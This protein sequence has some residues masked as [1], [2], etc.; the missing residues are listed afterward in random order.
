MHQPEGEPSATAP[1]DAASQPFGGDRDAE[2]PFKIGSRES[3]IPFPQGVGGDQATAYI[4]QRLKQLRETH[5]QR[6]KSA[7]YRPDGNGNGAR[8]DGGSEEPVRPQRGEAHK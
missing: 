8:P 1:P 4:E 6:Q 7:Q 5:A 2:S 3:E